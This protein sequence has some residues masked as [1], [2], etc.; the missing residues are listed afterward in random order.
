M[1]QDH[2]LIA[3]FQKHDVSVIEMRFRPLIYEGHPLRIRVTVEN[4][5]T[6]TETFGVSVVG[7]ETQQITLAPGSVQ[8]LLL[9]L[10]VPYSAYYE[11]TVMAAVVP[12]EI[13]TADNVVTRIGWICVINDWRGH[14]G[15]PRFLI[16]CE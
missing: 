6:Y 7:G 10:P 14:A 8:S 2:V 13:D 12:G 11:I 4:Q 1:D 9:G 15:A 5:G 3:E 16:C